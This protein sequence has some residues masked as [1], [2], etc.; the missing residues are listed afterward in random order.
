[1]GD[2]SLTYSSDLM[3]N[4]LQAEILSAESKLQALQTSDGSSLLFSVGTD[5]ALYLT[6][7]SP[8][9]RHGWDRYDISSAQIAADFPQP[10]GITC[11]HFA[12]AQSSLAE[13]ALVHLGMVLADSQ[14]DHLYLSLGNSDTDTSWAAAPPWT[15]FPF[16]NPDPGHRL[17]HVK[18]VN[19]FISEASDGDYIV[20]DVLTNQASSQPTVFRYYIDPDM[21]DGYAWHPHDLAADVQADR[22]LSCL[23]RRA[24]DV[25]DGL[26]TAGHV[27]TAAQFIY[28]PLYNVYN[29]GIARQSRG[30]PC[31]GACSRRPSARADART[32]APT[33][34]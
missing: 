20:V 27:G 7:E 21:D 14:D 5:D 25:V 30:S 11:K 4:Y 24:G 2:Y 23:G 15:S 31:Q 3:R 19:L 10:S 6:R 8:L 22:Y 1:M 26:Y 28:Q 18:I 29:P 33:C 34:T 12:S 13:E 17:S 16:D 9:T 32:T